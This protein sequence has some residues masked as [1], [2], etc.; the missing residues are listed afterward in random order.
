M[1]RNFAGVWRAW[2]RCQSFGQ[3]GRPSLRDLAATYRV[4]KASNSS[5][6]KR[7]QAMAL[8]AAAARG[9][10]KSKRSFGLKTQKLRRKVALQESIA[11]WKRT[12]GLSPLEK[13]LQ[14]ASNADTLDMDALR[15]LARRHEWL[16]RAQ[17]KSEVTKAELSLAKFE[18]EVGAE[19][20]RELHNALPILPME[21]EE[22]VALPSTS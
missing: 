20:K 19:I 11:H 22:L 3:K 4:A 8:S 13:A 2:V 14:L 10:G 21:A 1:K 16:D 12:Q 5:E 17:K 9:S 6:Y 18:K 15:K 7:A